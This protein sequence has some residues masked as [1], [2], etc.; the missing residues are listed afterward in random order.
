MK[1]R[2]I[3]MNIRSIS[4]R[5]HPYPSVSI[6][7]ESIPLSLFL[8]RESSFSHAWMVPEVSTDSEVYVSANAHVSVHENIRISISVISTSIS[9]S[10]AL[11]PSSASVNVNASLKVKVNVNVN[12]LA[13]DIR[14]T[15]LKSI[16]YEV[17]LRSVQYESSSGQQ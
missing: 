16:K 13:C 3:S 1:I 15:R 5:I 17:F 9:C 2:S 6:N 11:A 8:S 4:I 14:A 12:V 10:I 7:G